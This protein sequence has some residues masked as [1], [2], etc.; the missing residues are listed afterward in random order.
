MLIY[1]NLG[2]PI[3]RTPDARL[4]FLLPLI[5][6]DAAAPTLTLEVLRDGRP[7]VKAPLTVGSPDA[8]GRIQQIGQLPLS[9]LSPGNYLLRL[10][11]EQGS[12][13]EVREGAFTVADSAE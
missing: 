13:L 5:V 6:R 11:V 7:L 1:P 2:E 8:E 4:A 10:T 12:S 3:R 9:T